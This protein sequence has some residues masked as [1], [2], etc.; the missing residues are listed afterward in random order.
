MPSDVK[1]GGEQP[2]H[3]RPARSPRATACVRY[4]LPVSSTRP[5]GRVLLTEPPARK[6]Q[7]GGDAEQTEVDS[8]LQSL[9][10]A[11]EVLEALEAYS[12]L[13]VL[14]Q[15]GSYRSY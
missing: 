12:A 9:R 1:A 8:A 2:R 6:H 7:L 11:A 3:R 15:F 10:G 13:L 14:E 5:G 4:Y